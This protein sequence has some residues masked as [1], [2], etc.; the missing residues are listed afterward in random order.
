MKNENLIH[1]R[2]GY[3]EALQS[4]TDI[5][6]SEMNLI[7]IMKTI[8]K[9]RFLRL[10]EL[11]TKLKL[12]QK[13]KEV[14]TGIKKVQKTL[15]ELKIPEI[16]QKEKMPEESRELEIKETSYNRDLEFQL[17]NIQEKLNAL[18]RE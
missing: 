6:S 11:K 3:E 2:L 8:R 9:Y 18:Q 12:H 1:I 4:K 17:K 7:N 5:L 14:V 15:P 10:K 13:I 16:L